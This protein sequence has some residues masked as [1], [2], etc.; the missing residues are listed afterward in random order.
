[1]TKGTKREHLTQ[2][3][4]EG[5]CKRAKRKRQAQ[6]REHLTQENKERTAKRTKREEIAHNGTYNKK[7]TEQREKTSIKGRTVNIITDRQTHYLHCIHGGNAKISL[8]LH[9]PTVIVD[10]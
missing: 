6:D 9:C 5:T 3:C 2:L 8:Q 1:M 10:A 7:R 4:K